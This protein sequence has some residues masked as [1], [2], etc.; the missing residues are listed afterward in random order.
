M[1]QTSALGAVLLTA[2][3]GGAVAAHV[4]I[5]EPFAAPVVLGLLVWGGLFLRD[6]RVRALLPLRKL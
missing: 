5:G 1:P 4:R 2:Y 3:L 6:P